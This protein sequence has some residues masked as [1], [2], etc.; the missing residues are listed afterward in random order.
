MR[1]THVGLT[2]LALVLANGATVASQQGQPVFRTS[3]DHVAL[4]VVVTDSQDRPVTDLTKDD[5]VVRERGVRQ[6]I[7]DFSLVSIIAGTRRV[8]LD[9]TPAP[10][11]DVATNAVSRVQSRAIAIVVDDT[12][13]STA[14]IVPIKRT[15]AALL[16]AVSPDDQVA[17]TYIRQSDLGQDFTNDSGKLVLAAN[18]LN[19]AMGLPGVAAGEMEARDFLTVLDNVVSTLGGARQSRRFIVLVSFRGC[20]PHQLLTPSKTGA[21]VSAICKGVIDKAN[22][23]GVPIYGLD[24]TGNLLESETASNKGS[25]ANL[26]VAT[27]GR[28]YRFAEPAKSAAALMADNGHYYL[29][30]YYPSPARDD[31]RFQAVDVSVRRPGLQVRARKGYTAPSGQIVASSPNR[32]MSAALSAGLP[33]PGLPIRAFVAP[34]RDIGRNKVRCIVTI[35]VSYPTASQEDRTFKDDWRVGILALDTDGR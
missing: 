33:N 19:A 27:G 24:P 25:L 21:G 5:F 31:G 2:Y 13:L 18:R 15:L 9:A 14:D 17:L 6:Q 23:T 30:G 4:D 1:V 16:S 32:A 26:A 34:M 11:V 3:T 8:D 10:P 28:A 22:E 35:E 7:A 12:I 20:N 29:I